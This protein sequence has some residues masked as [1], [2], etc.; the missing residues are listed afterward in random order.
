L[1][2]DLPA[3]L[4]TAFTN[5]RNEIDGQARSRRFLQHLLVTALEGAIAAAKP[6]GRTIGI[7]QHLDLYMARTLEELLSIDLWVAE[8]AA[9][10]LTDERKRIGKLRM[11]SDDP[12][13]ATA[14]AAGRLED[15]RKTNLGGN[16]LQGFRIVGKG[17]LPRAWLAWRRPYRPSCGCTLGLAR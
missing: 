9:R 15:Q 10:F 3:G 11:R 7:G 5:P 8:G 4:D 17:S 2:A 6:K 12:H 13:T 1:V 14:S 16:G